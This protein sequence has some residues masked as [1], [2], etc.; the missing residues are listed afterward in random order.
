MTTNK[1][2]IMTL[3]LG[4][5][6]ILL[7]G[8]AVAQY[9]PTP[10]PSNYPSGQIPGMIPTIAPI[11]TL[12]PPDISAYN[13]TM[14]DMLGNGTLTNWNPT[15]VMSDWLSPYTTPMGLWFWVLVYA[16][17]FIGAYMFSDSFLIPCF[18]TIIFSPIFYTVLPPEWQWV[19]GIL[20]AMGIAGLVFTLL[21]KR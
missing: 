4:G 7:S 2:I 3:L 12:T 18:L 15:Q 6:I 21:R 10:Y 13:N 5:L 14:N 20:V 11:T 9:V 16:A 17:I 8:T 19:S 1:K